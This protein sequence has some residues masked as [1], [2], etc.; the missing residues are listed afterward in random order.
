MG[1]ELLEL[2]YPPIDKFLYR[3]YGYF[4]KCFFQMSIFQQQSISVS[5]SNARV[6]KWQSLKHAISHLTT[7]N[8]KNSLSTTFLNGLEIDLGLVECSWQLLG[9]VE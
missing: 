3:P 4:P 2:T 5:F 6:P 7:I 8:S 9:P 1:C